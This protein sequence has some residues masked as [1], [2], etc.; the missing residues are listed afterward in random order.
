M[1]KTISNESSREENFILNPISKFL[2][3]K[4]PKEQDGKLLIDYWK[5]CFITRYLFGD[6]IDIDKMM[7]SVSPEE[8]YFKPNP[9]ISSS[10]NKWLEMFKNDAHYRYIFLDNIPGSSEPLS[11]VVKGIPEESVRALR[12]VLDKINTGAMI[13]RNDI[14][15]AIEDHREYEY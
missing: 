2:V 14:K 8:L 5:A 9:S 11:M 7:I 3:K 10:F 12:E 13:S 15:K 4:F 1:F 6:N